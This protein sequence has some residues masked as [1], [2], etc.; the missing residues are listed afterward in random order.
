MIDPALL[1][2]AAFKTELAASRR[3]MARTGVPEADALAQ[4]LTRSAG[5][6]GLA[7]LLAE[8]QAQRQHAGQQAARRQA[9][10]SAS[11]TRGAGPGTSA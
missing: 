7:H 9:L 2:A 10:A 3:L 11:R 6:A 4:I 5:M 1:H 8:R